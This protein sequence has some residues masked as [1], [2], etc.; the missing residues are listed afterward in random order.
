M[1]NFNMNVTKFK[2]K[3][4]CLYKWKA[5]LHSSIFHVHV[6]KYFYFFKF[7]QINDDA[8]H[9][10]PIA[11]LFKKVYSIFMFTKNLRLF[12]FYPLYSLFKYFKIEIILQ[13]SSFFVVLAF[14]DVNNFP[15]MSHV[16]F[17]Q[18][19]SSFFVLCSV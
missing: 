16:V 13:S 7:I 19:S 12:S 15:Q 17:S 10:S 5:W 14:P 2:N 4:S 18:S 1:K 3:W 8:D 11:D 9:W 6:S